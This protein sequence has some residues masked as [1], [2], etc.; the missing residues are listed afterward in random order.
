MDRAAGILEPDNPFLKQV[1]DSMQAG[2]SVLDTDL[3]IVAVNA[4][5][6]KMYAH[7]L[8]LQG[9]HCYRAYQE[10][11]RACPWCPVV[12]TLQ[13]GQTSISRVPYTA[14]GEVKGHLE[15]SAY[16]MFSADG[17]LEGVIEYVRDITEQVQSR[18]ALEYEKEKFRLF[19]DFTANWE[20]WISQ[21]GQLIYSSPACRDITGYDPADFKQDPSLLDRLVHPRDRHLFTGHLEHVLPRGTSDCQ[22]S[23]RII[24][25]HGRLRWV[26]H[27]CRAVFDSRGEYLGRRASN[28][29]ITL[30]KMAEDSLME[31]LKELNCLYEISRLVNKD[32]DLH[33]I[34]DGVVDTIPSGLQYP[35]QA[36]IRIEVSGQSFCTHPSSEPHCII[37]QEIV[38]ESES[39]GRVTVGYQQI[40]PEEDKGPFLLEEVNLVQSIADLLAGFMGR[41]NMQKALLESEEKLR[42]ILEQTP[43]LICR[44]QADGTIEYVNQAYCRFFNKSREELTGTNFLE[45]I[46]PE[47]RDFVKNHFNSL[48]PDNPQ[49]SYEHRV[50]GPDGR[51]YWQSWVDQ[52]L[53]DSANNLQAYQSVGRDITAQK[54]AEEELRLANRSLRVLHLTGEA[55]ARATDKA[56]LWEK[57]CR[58]LVEN[59]GY[60]LA[61]VGLCGEDG[62]NRVY[63][64]AQAGY[65][66]G[67][68]E[69]ITITRDDSPTGQGPTGTAIRTGQTRICR[70]ILTDPAFAPWRS[71]ARKYG[72][73]SSISLPLIQNESVLGALN[74]YA[75]E[76]DA[77]DSREAE[78]LQRLAANLVFGMQALDT[79]NRLEQSAQHLEQAQAVGK[80]GSWNMDLNGKNFKLS[81]QAY[82]ILEAPPG[83]RITWE[84]IFSRVHPGDRERVQQEWEIAMRKKQAFDSVH[85]LQ[86]RDQVKWVRVQSILQTDSQG[87]PV[88]WLGVAQDITAQKEAEDREKERLEQ[89][90]QASKMAALGTLV[91]GVGH[92]I[93]NPNN[94]IMLNAPMLRQIWDDALP[95][96]EEYAREHGEFNLAGM[97]LSSIREHIPGLFTG[98]I[99]GSKRIKHIV[100]DLKDFARQSPLQSGQEADMNQVVEKA[101]NLMGRMIAKYTDNFRVEYGEN[102]PVVHG[103]FQKLEQVI[104]NL[105][106]NA[107]QALTDRR[108]LVLVRTA[109]EPGEEAVLVEVRDEG[110]GI[111]PEQQERI[112]DPFFSTRLKEG[113]TGLGL[114][115]TSSIVQDHGG[116]LEFD[117][118]PG[119]GTTVRLYLYPQQPRSET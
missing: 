96:L 85:R 4:W 104:M 114:S 116:R 83:S 101:L 32:D 42:T 80:M 108:G 1:L 25:R 41:R 93:N 106:I 77:F 43:A 38:S 112:C 21:E 57:V 97:P 23:F 82:H 27:V 7:H 92:E 56:W 74:I 86:I 111:D 22:L 28:T 60:V 49:V 14:E 10:R 20:Y 40:F 19:A 91:A 95:V 13:S 36:W 53:F 70:N 34:M 84:M 51:L 90:Q 15:V 30:R 18:E 107:C 73:A 119:Q 31:R 47:D 110:R 103:D 94:F 81:K 50:Q 68:L 117:S 76:P 26:Q 99:D 98:I 16:P 69:H 100:S 72:Y 17:Q 71:Q 105:V 75:R 2:I 62:D 6:E 3:R 87:V 66:P 89:L 78:L 102:I 5:M 113:G 9:K 109:Y 79:W 12:K 67:Y 24:D 58:I 48:T 37:S 54:E 44:F 8:P 33:T 59:G 64:V 118:S 39:L 65:E 88:Q 52:A 11:D 46:P 55:M 63:P 45:L 35:E 29:E 61:W 115:I